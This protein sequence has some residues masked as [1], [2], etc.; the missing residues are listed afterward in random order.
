MKKIKLYKCQ[1]FKA[2]RLSKDKQ[3]RS[4]KLLYTSYAFGRD[5]QEATENTLK[6]ARSVN[7]FD[8]LVFTLQEVHYGIMIKKLLT[9]RSVGEL[10][11]S[12]VSEP[13]RYS[14]PCSEHWKKKKE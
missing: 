2:G 5:V 4:S 1:W 8:D 6:M 12:E 7:Y 9:N 3:S 14:P 10:L 13:T 11:G